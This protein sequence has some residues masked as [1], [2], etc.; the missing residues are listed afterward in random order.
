MDLKAREAFLQRLDYLST[1]FEFLM[2]PQGYR[3]DAFVTLLMSIAEH[4][5]INEYVKDLPVIPTIGRP[6]FVHETIES[7]CRLAYQHFFNGAI[8]AHKNMVKLQASGIMLTHVPGHGA[9]FDL[10]KFYIHIPDT[11]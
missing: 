4:P 3:F 11:E 2:N 1:Y 5:G 6:V 7:Y 9:F 10:D 8:N